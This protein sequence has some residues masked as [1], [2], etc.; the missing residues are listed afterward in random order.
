MSGGVGWFVGRKTIFCGGTYSW[1][2][3]DSKSEYQEGRVWASWGK[4]M[5]GRPCKKEKLMTQGN[6]NR[7]S[8]VKTQGILEKPFQLNFQ[9]HFW[10][11]RPTTVIAGSD[12]YFHTECQSVCP[13]TWKSSD[14]HCRP[15]LWAGRVDHWWLQSC[16]FY[17]HPSRC[18][19]WLRESLN[20]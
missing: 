17:I 15:G 14:N 20:Y 3:W 10:S 4:I 12:H 9:N 2:R 8:V 5:S 18:R 7:N 13:K 11:T 19:N 1:P 6:W 16:S